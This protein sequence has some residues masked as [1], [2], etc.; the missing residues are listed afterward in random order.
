MSLYMCTV[1][2][3]AFGPPGAKTEIRPRVL[4]L[5]DSR[6]AAEQQALGG[7]LKPNAMA[8][9][10]SP[11]YKEH[12]NALPQE[13]LFHSTWSLDKKKGPRTVQHPHAQP[14]SGSS[15]PGKRESPEGLNQY[16]RVW[17]M[18]VGQRGRWNR[19]RKQEFY[20]KQDKDMMSKKPTDEKNCAHE[21]NYKF[22]TH[23]IDNG[24]KAGGQEEKL[25]YTYK[26]PNTGTTHFYLGKYENV[27]HCQRILTTGYKDPTT[28]QCRDLSKDK[29]DTFDNRLK[30]DMI[31]YNDE[32]DR[33]RAL[34]GYDL[35]RPKNTMSCPQL[36]ADFISRGF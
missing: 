19:Q 9:A 34:A 27:K 6:P 12:G 35:F 29:R 4:K 31:R 3:T 24:L 1:P 14:W 30:D 21:G 26:G 17:L 11:G 15:C 22:W 10:V 7:S 18:E 2:I 28:D 5:P 36:G 23:L 33:Q 25:D 8:S 32:S 20:A 16:H 13:P